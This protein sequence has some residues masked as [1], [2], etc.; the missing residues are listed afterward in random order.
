MG[1]S[2]ITVV[3]ISVSA[4]EASLRAA[5][6]S[7]WLL[8]IGVVRFN[9]ARDEIWQPSEY[10]SGPGATA[11]APQVN[12][13]AGQLVNNG[14]DIIA[15]RRFYSPDENYGPPDCPACGETLDEATHVDLVEPWLAGPEP[16]VTCDACGVQTPIGDWIADGNEWG[17]WTFHVGQ[18]AVT[19]NNW[20]GLTRDFR[21]ELGGRMGPRWRVIS[22]HM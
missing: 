6:L 7:R 1:E 2:S 13:P 11:V 17:Q 4:H 3:E 14:V 5:E 21:S 18:L 10:R 22:A 19:F 20:P 15:Q 12:N 9:T 16:I 8:D